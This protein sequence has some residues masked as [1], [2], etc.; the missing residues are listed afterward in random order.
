MAGRHRDPESHREL[1]RRAWI[2]PD[3]GG[4]LHRD[5]R[6]RNHCQSAA[7]AAFTDFSCGDRFGY[8]ARFKNYQEFG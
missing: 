7:P 4:A 8:Y 3:D 6:G 2:G 5:C 1:A